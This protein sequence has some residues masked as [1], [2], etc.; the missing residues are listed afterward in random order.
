MHTAA[1]RF[2]V[3]T[4]HSHVSGNS[5]FVGEVTVDFLISNSANILILVGLVLAV[6]AGFTAGRAGRGEISLESRL[7]HHE[8]Q[9]KERSRV[10]AALNREQNSLQNLALSLPQVVQQL[11]RADLD[12]KKIPG[13]IF[14][15]ANAIFQPEQM[16]FFRAKR[17]R[18]RS[19]TRMELQLEHHQG[20][21]PVPASVMRI[22]FGQGKLGWVAEHKLDKLSNEWSNMTASDGVQAMSGMRNL[23]LDIIGP[24]SHHNT[25]GE[26][27]LGVLSIGAPTLHPKN[28]KLMFQMVTNLG[29]L[30]L[31]NSLNVSK[32]REQAN[33]DGLTGLLNKRYFMHEFAIA[34][35]ELS[36]EANN[37]S[38]FIFD[39]DHFKTYNDTNGHPAGDE[40]LRS[41]SALLK[42]WNRSS[43]MCCRYGGEEFLV[44]MPHT[45]GEEALAIA[46][47]IRKII[48]EFNF[49]HQENQPSGNL[50]ISG[51]V[52]SYP[53]DGVCLEELI[54]NADQALYKSKESGRNT[55]ARYQVLGLPG[56][57]VDTNHDMIPSIDDV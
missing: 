55:V 19:G 7:E 12:S 36:R 23:K 5:A 52:A 18:D 30:A 25:R 37:Y 50:T 6:V 3:R 57:E 41:L 32:L 22:P 13:L 39:I 42:E 46:E 11:N 15:L 45:G 49:E 43:D 54:R 14:N 31:V 9:S 47:E 8:Q 16:L 51:G 26:E 20:L 21:N 34:S 33:H 10:V 2:T 48:E 35:V 44:G 1:S 38:V 56:I 17:V 24:L 27:V 40:L 4:L 53:D 29:S 28:E